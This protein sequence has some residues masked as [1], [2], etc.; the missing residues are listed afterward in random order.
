MLLPTLEVVE[1]HVAPV[2]AQR[3]FHR[4]ELELVLLRDRHLR[5]FLGR[6]QSGL[7]RRA[8]DAVR[9]TSVDFATSTRCC[10]DARAYYRRS[11]VC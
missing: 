3:V 10:D 7:L 9:V 1:F 6:R 4:D 8:R 5:L 2:E 11:S